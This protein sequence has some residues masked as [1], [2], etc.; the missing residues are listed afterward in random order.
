[1][2]KSY[3]KDLI[4]FKTDN[5]IKGI[6]DCLSFIGKILSEFGWKIRILKNKQNE[7]NNFVAMY[8]GD[9][10]HKRNLLLN[11]LLF[12]HINLNFHVVITTNF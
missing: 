9:L 3:L 12:C 10:V 5:N 8:N 11:E 7:K 2:E 6:N 4:R 1:M